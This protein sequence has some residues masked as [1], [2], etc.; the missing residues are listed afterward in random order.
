MDIRYRATLEN[1]REAKLLLVGANNVLKNLEDNEGSLIGQ[2]I[3]RNLNK[4]K[5]YVI[6]KAMSEEN[7]GVK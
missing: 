7:K 1:I 2:G 5:E 3:L 4:L 6:T